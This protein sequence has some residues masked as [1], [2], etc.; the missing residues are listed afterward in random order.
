MK[1]DHLEDQP[2]ARVAAS[3]TAGRRAR[4]Q[5]LLFTGAALGTTLLTLGGLID[6]KIPPFKSE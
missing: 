3:C 5:A 4:L 2:A 6:P 1:N